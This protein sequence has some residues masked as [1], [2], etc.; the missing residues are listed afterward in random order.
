MND[1]LIDISE[2]A[3]VLTLENGLLVIHPDGKPKETVPIDEIAAIV[4]S[5][6]GVVFG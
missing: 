4:T 1:R 5:H 3:A 2:S 6:R